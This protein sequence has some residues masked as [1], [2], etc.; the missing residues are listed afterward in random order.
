MIRIANRLATRCYQ[1][2][3]SKRWLHLHE[4]QSL[5]LMKD[6]GLQVQNG[7]VAFTPSEARSVAQGL[8]NAYRKRHGDNDA[9]CDL[10]VKAQIHAGGRGK[11]FFS[12][13]YHGGVQILADPSEVFEASGNMLGHTL[14]T[15]QTGPQGQPVRALLI[16]EGITILNEMYLAILL[17][18]KY[19]GPVIV[20]SKCGGMDIEEVAES[21]PDEITAIPIDIAIGVTDEQA[22]QAVTALGLLPFDL[23][24]QGKH[25]VKR[26]YELFLAK[27]ATQVEINPLAVAS[28]GNLYCVDAKLN[29]DDCAS[30]R[31]PELFEQRDTTME[32]QRELKAE[33][34]G[35][36]YIALDGNIGCLVNGAGLAMGTMDI[37]KLHGA[38][39]ANFLDVGGGAT[40]E[41]VKE[42]FKIIT[43]DPNVKVILV[44]IFGGIMKCDV[45][46]RGII[47]ASK[48]LGLDQ[49]DIP[50]VVRLEGTNVKEGMEALEQ[51]G[52]NVITA[53]DLDDAAK[54]L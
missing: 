26:L 13:G 24:E 39:P 3:H 48:E 49:M 18:R 34:I 32:D 53:T 42:A 30:Y 37:I 50:L 33:E 36:N 15:K 28:D 29:F 43:S 45:I 12:N 2:H 35:L 25:Q 16:N 44:N 46:A 7:S 52:I 10:I 20:A 8:L 54:K 41:Q 38:S 9:Q 5:K 22:E 4:Y 40:Q 23:R 47:N 11:G 27:D 51:S 31:Q 1:H 19:S 14:V 6:G 17:D 21:T